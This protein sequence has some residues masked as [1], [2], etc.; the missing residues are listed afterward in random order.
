V[1][2]FHCLVAGV[3]CAGPGGE[4]VLQLVDDLVES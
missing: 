1:Y 3:A 2:G 4:Q